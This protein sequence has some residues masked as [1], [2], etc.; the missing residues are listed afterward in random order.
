MQS[1]AASSSA[2]T[3]CRDLRSLGVHVVVVAVVVASMTCVL[4]KAPQE[5]VAGPLLG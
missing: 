1:C 5:A 2:L 4:A 3:T